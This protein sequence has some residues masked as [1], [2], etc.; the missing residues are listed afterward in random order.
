MVNGLMVIV[1]SGSVFLTPPDPSVDG[2]FVESPYSTDSNGRDL[3]LGGI[4]ADGNLMQLQIFRN[5]LG[6]HD[7]WHN[8]NSSHRFNGFFEGQ[9]GPITHFFR[10]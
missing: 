2:I 8:I 1:N 7:F 9:A 4:F 3:S 5:F 10:L 6:R